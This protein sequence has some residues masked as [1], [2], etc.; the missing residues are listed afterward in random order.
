MSM[1][2]AELVAHALRDSSVRKRRPLL[3][4]GTGVYIG[5]DELMQSV[6]FWAA[7]KPIDE[8]AID[9]YIEKV[10]GQRL[11]GVLRRQPQYYLPTAVFRELRS[12][13]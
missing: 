6:N 8:K 12:R 9:D 2:I 3:Y 1:S 11:G 13:E 5:A 10:G 4:Y 7:G